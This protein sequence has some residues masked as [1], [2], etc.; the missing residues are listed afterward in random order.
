MERKKVSIITLG[1]KVN[2]YESGQIAKKLEENNIDVFLE[3]KEADAY[4]INTCAVTNE[5]EKKSRGIV[6][7][8]R[9]LSKDAPIY[10]TGC[11]SQ[12]DHTKFN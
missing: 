10:V 7:K 8:I 4:V 3:L 9:K 6:A 11:S 2:Q 5:A 12:N 1:C